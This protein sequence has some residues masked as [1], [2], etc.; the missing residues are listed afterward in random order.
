M[1]VFSENNAY[2]DRI[3]IVSLKIRNCLYYQTINIYEIYGNLVYLIYI[4]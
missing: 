1:I 2:L 3:L 4:L